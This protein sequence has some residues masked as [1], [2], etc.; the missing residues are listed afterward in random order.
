MIIAA[1][2]DTR[3]HVPQSRLCVTPVDCNPPKAP[4]RWVAMPPRGIFW[5]KDQA[6]VS[7]HLQE[8]LV[9]SLLGRPNSG[10]KIEC[11]VMNSCVTKG[12]IGEE[13]KNTMPFKSFKNTPDET[14]QNSANH[15]RTVS[16]LTA[17]TKDLN[18]GGCS[19]SWT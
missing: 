15:Q 8:D 12:T 4:I 11:K 10:Y 6:W 7:L 3:L 17:E 16:K 9:L 19:C 18:G 14:R 2:H 1:F 13:I 5:P